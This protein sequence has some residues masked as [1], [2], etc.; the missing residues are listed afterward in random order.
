MLCVYS[1]KARDRTED[2]Q[3]VKELD[4]NTHHNLKLEIR[5]LRHTLKAFPSFC[6]LV[7]LFFGWLLMVSIAPF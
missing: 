7:S 1:M 3:A 5:E 6:F 4:F 2:L